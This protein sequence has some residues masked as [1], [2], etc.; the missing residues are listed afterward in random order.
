MQEFCVLYNDW[1]QTKTY[2]WVELLITSSDISQWK[3][4]VTITTTD[5]V[6]GSWGQK[7][8]VAKAI[9]AFAA[10][11][12]KKVAEVSEAMVAKTQLGIKG[13]AELYATCPDAAPKPGGDG[14]NAPAPPPPKSNKRKHDGDAGDQVPVEG[15]ANKQAKNSKERV[16]PKKEREVKELLAQ[17]QSADNAMAWVASEM[18][19]DPAWWSW[20]RESVQSY[21]DRRTEVLQMYCDSAVFQNLKVAALS[22]AETS[23]LRKSLGDDYVPKLVEFCTSLGPRIQ[24][25]AESAFQVESMA[26]AKK[27]A[28]DI[29]ERQRSGQNPKAKP[30]G[31]GKAKAK[32]AKRASSQASLAADEN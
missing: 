18:K 12:R 3:N 17:E 13:W 21:K 2:F 19:R 23:K 1:L 24:E 20:A 6:E 30:K 16:G 14:T 26:K 31:K 9:R 11:K 32:G 22:P 29:L 15:L 5:S 4:T 10:S 27:G 25:M 7:V 28:K 8:E